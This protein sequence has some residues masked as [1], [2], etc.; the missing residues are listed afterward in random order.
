MI[1]SVCSVTDLK[2]AY[3]MGN[4][5]VCTPCVSKW[6]IINK[7]YADSLSTEIKEVE[8]LD[9]NIYGIMKWSDK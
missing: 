1:C 2:L 3:C 5:I 7:A 9:D 4:S 6:K 8:S